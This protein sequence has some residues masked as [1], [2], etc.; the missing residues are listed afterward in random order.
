[1]FE[2]RYKARD[3]GFR[4]STTD[5]VAIGVFTCAAVVLWRLDSPLWWMLVITAGHFFLFCNVFR[6]DRRHELI[7]A[8]LFIVNV[9]VWVWFDHLSWAGV[10][11]C[12]LP[13]TAGLVVANMRAP[14]YH[15]VF[16]DR[17]NPKPNGHLEGRIP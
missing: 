15:G 10:L 3:R 6:I 4:F 1:M 17:L 13:V 14:G 2:T 8:A 16:A 11:F 9:G 7:W 12:Q 5:A